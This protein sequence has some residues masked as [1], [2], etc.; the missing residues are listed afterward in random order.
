MPGEGDSVVATRDPILGRSSC[1]RDIDPIHNACTSARTGFLPGS[2]DSILALELLRSRVTSGR[3]ESAESIFRRRVLDDGS[4]TSSSTNARRGEISEGE[5]E[6]E[7][8]RKSLREKTRIWK[9]NMFDITTL[10]I[11]LLIRWLE[12]FGTLGI[13]TKRIFE[14]K[15]SE[16]F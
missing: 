11:I 8:A 9:S 13:S 5:R 7:T 2:P 10:T 14:Y 15:M 6:S 4:F 16:F 3:A 1:R 12:M